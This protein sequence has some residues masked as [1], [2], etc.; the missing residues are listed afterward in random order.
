MPTV[1]RAQCRF[2]APSLLARSTFHSHSV[3]RPGQALTY[4]SPIRLPFLHYTPDTRPPTA[5]ALN[6]K[7][8]SIQRPVDIARFSISY[9]P[10]VHRLPAIQHLYTPP[11]QS[12]PTTPP[13]LNPPAT[14]RTTAARSRP[15]RNRLCTTS[16]SPSP[17]TSTSTSP[18][19]LPRPYLP[20]SGRPAALSPRAANVEYSV[21]VLRYGRRRLLLESASPCCGEQNAHPASLASAHT[22]AV[23]QRLRSPDTDV[24]ESSHHHLHLFRCCNKTDSPTQPS[25]RSRHHSV[26]LFLLSSQAGFPPS[27]AAAGLHSPERRTATSNTAYVAGHLEEHEHAQVQPAPA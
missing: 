14:K 6:K 23:K 18:A 26:P 2:G 16:P 20:Q 11:P 10:R 19:P 4:L 27:L 12:Q 8:Y 17:S 25:L 24:P 7:H 3:L 9:Q 13:R 22:P 1:A 5:P 15:R 21:A